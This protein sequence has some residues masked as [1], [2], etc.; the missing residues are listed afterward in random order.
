M[1]KV[2]NYNVEVD[3]IKWLIFMYRAIEKSSIGFKN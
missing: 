3:E 2:G 1:Y